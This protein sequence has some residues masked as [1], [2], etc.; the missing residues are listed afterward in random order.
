VYTHTHTHTHTHTQRERERERERE[1]RIGK[2]KGEDHG[3]RKGTRKGNGIN[4]I[5]FYKE[6]KTH[7]AIVK[8][9]DACMSRCSP[10]FL[11]EGMPF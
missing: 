8:I 2:R 5:K 6:T 1:K 10:G 3:E 4:I 11:R 7:F 9:K